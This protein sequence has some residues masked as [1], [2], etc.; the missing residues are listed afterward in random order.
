MFFKDKDLIIDSL[1]KN[2]PLTIKAIGT[3]MWPFI[4]EGDLVLLEESSLEKIDV[5]DLVVYV[6]PKKLDILIS[7]RVVKKTGKSLIS[8]GDG[9]LFRYDIIRGCDLVGR[10]KGIIR[11]EGYINLD[12]NFY[13]RF[14]RTI[15]CLSLRVPF[16]LFIYNLLL[17]RC[18]FYRS[19]YVSR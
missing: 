1:R 9:W 4:R 5:G 19:R 14:N 2:G 16:L 8:K 15:A 17:W 12:T 13:K 6:K 10:L 18:K 7:H 3:S 11:K